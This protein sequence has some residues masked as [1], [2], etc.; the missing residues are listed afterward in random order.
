[1]PREIAEVILPPLAVTI[2]GIAWIQANAWRVADARP[3]G[4]SAARPVFPQ[5]AALLILLLIFQL[6]LRPGIPFY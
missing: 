5:L 6:L 4:F 2:L 1:M 3:G